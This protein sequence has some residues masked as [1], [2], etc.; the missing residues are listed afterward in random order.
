MPLS[1]NRSQ[2][3][4]IFDFFAICFFLL[5]IFKG[6]DLPLSFQRFLSPPVVLVTAIQ[7]SPGRP[8]DSMAIWLE[9]SL[10]HGFNVCLRETKIFDGLHQNIKIV[11]TQTLFLM[12][13]LSRLF[14]R[15][16]SLWVHSVALMVQRLSD[17]RAMWPAHLRF[18]FLIA[19][20]ISPVSWRIQV[21][22]FR[23]R[24]IMPSII[25]S[26]LLFAIASLSMY[27]SVVQRPCL[28]PICH[29]W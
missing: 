23:S 13:I 4:N 29:Y 17:N 2:S 15:P 19:L 5:S 8:Q 12:P 21:F 11:S 18:T 24:R 25:R 10:E 9:Y 7:Q 28:A 20:M 1:L 6:F 14:C 22:R 16:I 3:T 27:H 26:I